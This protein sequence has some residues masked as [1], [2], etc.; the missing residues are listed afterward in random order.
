M[1]NQI[2]LSP[3]LIIRDGTF[4]IIKLLGEGGS[5]RV[6]LAEQPL[7]GNQQIAIKEPLQNIGE[8]TGKQILARFEHEVNICGYLEQINVPNI[9]HARSVQ[10]YGSSKLLV[11]DYMPGGDLAS[12]ISKGQIPIKEVVKISAQALKAMDAFHNHMMKIVHRDIKPTNI[13][14]DSERKCIFR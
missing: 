1:D 6:W 9:V 11:M 2:L 10:P 4:K 13:L 3:C 12:K 8:D 7:F 5:S 14:F